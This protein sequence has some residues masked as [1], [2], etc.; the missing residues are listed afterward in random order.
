M[1]ARRA[2]LLA[3]WLA[4]LAPPACAQEAEPPPEAP[5]GDWSEEVAD[6][7][8]RG[9][10]ETTFSSRGRAGSAPR[11]GE[12]LR[13]RGEG[14][15]GSVRSGSDPVAGARLESAFGRG[16]LRAGRLAPRWG[17]G[18][19]VGGAAQAWAAQA[20]DRGDGAPVRGHAADGALW[21]AEGGACEMLAARY[22]RVGI[23]GA[24]VAHGPVSLAGIARGAAWQGAVAFADDGRAAEL[25]ADRAGRWRAEF[26]AWRTDEPATLALRVRTGHARFRSLA[27]PLRA[28]PAT[29]ASAGANAAGETIAARALAAWWRWAPEQGG[30]VASLEVRTRLVHHAEVAVGC[31]E[32]HG[33][34]RDPASTAAPASASG[35]RQGWWCSWRGRTRGRALELRHELRGSR[36]FARDAVRRTLAASGESALPFGASLAVTHRTWATRSGESLWLAESDGDLLTLR[37]ATGS[38]ARTQVVL[39]VPGL[40]GRA[41]AVAEWTT[42]PSRR[43]APGWSLEWTRRT[44]Q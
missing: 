17:R 30:A 24:R 21:S 31:D 25:A 28:G 35:L 39:A 10:V 1:S 44:R 11:S 34:R 7:L 12:K 16:T 36:A 4:T 23:A 43:T 15:A 42:V 41:R 9:W 38:G 26:S 2:A 19:L 33:T 32:Q 8:A 6:T 13:F 3:I 27:E 14:V 5:P 37:A 40:G 18:L 20:E 29:L 22:R